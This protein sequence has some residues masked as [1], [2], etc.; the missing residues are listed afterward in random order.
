M[1]QIRNPIGESRAVDRMAQEAIEEARIVLPGIQAL[2]GFQLIAAFTERFR[3]LTGG[4]QLLHY[5]AF[6][7]V[8]IAITLIMTPVAYH[9]LVE[10]D[11][12]SPFFIRLASW[13][14]AATMVPLML[15]LAFEVFIIGN[16]VLSAP[17]TSF[18]VAA[19]LFLL[20]SS[21]W[22]GF[23]LAMRRRRDSTRNASDLD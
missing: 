23:P 13:L 18:V 5:A 12:V 1:S 21:L 7:L 15:A 17:I 11:S 20:F 14:I 3:Q 8:A 10:R 22:F 9:R 2:F 6:V 16:L 4:E 19:A